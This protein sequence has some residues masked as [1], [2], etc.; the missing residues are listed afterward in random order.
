MGFEIVLHMTQS[1]P[2]G[3]IAVRTLGWRSVVVVYMLA[4]ALYWV[5]A[6]LIGHTQSPEA[7]Y[8]DHLA[9]A[10]LNGQT[11]LTEPPVIH[12]LTFYKGHWYVA[13]PPLPALLLLP[14]VAV[15]G[16]AQT[17]TVLFS[18]GMGALNV[19]LV[20][21]LLQH[22][23]Q[24]G[25]SQLNPCGNVWLTVLWGIGSVHWYMTV[26]G[27]VWFVSQICTATFTLLALWLALAKRAPLWV[28]GALGLA[29]L[30]RPHLML[31]YPFL[32]AIGWELG[33][34]DRNRWLRWAWLTGAPLV[35]S[36]LLLLGYNYVRFEDWANFG[37][38]T[39]NVAREL[40]IDLRR[41]GQFNPHYFPHNFWAMWLAGP[42]WE[43]RT[44]TLL[45][46]L[47]GMSLLLTTPA[48]V[49]ALRASQPRNF[50]WGAWVAVALLLIPL[51]TYYNTGWWQ[52]GYRFSLDFMPIVILLIALGAGPHV[53]RVLRLLIVVGIVINLWGVTWF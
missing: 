42:I 4:V 51:L 41:Y 7:A 38:Q 15:N 25:W 50:V 33:E 22:L 46:N 28:G 11:H 16:V 39:Q 13:F 32:L 29:V 20:F 14:W 12:D 10:F 34:R 19:A 35:L 40:L 23:S 3:N 24:R 31:V 5:T 44:H 30:A 27:S 18:S 2:I 48:I 6:L 9:Q 1:A 17:N 53:S 36:G 45:P 49:Y 52:F 21:S 43:A 8:F 47:D 26:Q 37:Y